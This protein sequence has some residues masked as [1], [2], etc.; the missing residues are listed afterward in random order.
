MERNSTKCRNYIRFMKI[1][2]LWL[3]RTYFYVEMYDILVMHVTY[4]LAH[5]THVS[6]NVTF[7]HFVVFISDLIKELATGQTRHKAENISKTS[8]HQF[9]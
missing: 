7:S 1:F 2:H 8:N 6:H 5:L 4:S 9:S 3:V